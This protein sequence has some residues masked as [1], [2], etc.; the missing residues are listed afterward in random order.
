MPST[1]KQAYALLRLT[2]GV[3]MLLHGLT[4]IGSGV[5]GF[6]STVTKEFQATMLPASLVHGFAFLLP[7]VEGLLGL[8]LI[9][10]L[11]TRGALI[12]GSLLMVALIFGTAL[13]SEWNTVGLQLLYA[14]IYSL[15]LANLEHNGYAIDALRGSVHSTRL[16]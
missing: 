1:K 10:G 13:R 8:F 4:R 11:F 15:L 14:L 7:F 16:T 5:D 2:M 9:L 12:L 6:A 3:D